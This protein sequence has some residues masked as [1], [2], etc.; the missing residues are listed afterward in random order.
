MFLQLSV[1]AATVAECHWCALSVLAPTY[2]PKIRG[3]LGVLFMFV[4][5]DVLL[6]AFAVACLC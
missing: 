3:V 4:V 1:C 2:C 5:V 6:Y